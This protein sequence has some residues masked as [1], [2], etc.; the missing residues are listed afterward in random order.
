MPNKEAYD[1]EE[2]YLKTGLCC[3]GHKTEE[4]AVVE[5]DLK[6]VPIKCKLIQREVHAWNITPPQ[7][8]RPR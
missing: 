3:C 8:Q 4:H 7:V 5:D 2:R 6:N 1:N